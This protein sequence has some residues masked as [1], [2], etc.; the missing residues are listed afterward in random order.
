MAA[1]AAAVGRLQAFDTNTGSASTSLGV[2]TR[3]AQDAVVKEVEIFN[4]V[5]QN[6]LRLE[7]PVF[8][9]IAV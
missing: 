5:R 6:R 1:A 7:W 4:S 8:S 2:S 3:L 9:F